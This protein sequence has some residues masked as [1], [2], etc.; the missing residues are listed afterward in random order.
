VD[1]IRAHR[2][3]G[4]IPAVAANIDGTIDTAFDIIDLMLW[5]VDLFTAILNMFRDFGDYLL[6]E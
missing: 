5:I 1:S 4:Q 3:T 2:M 6:G